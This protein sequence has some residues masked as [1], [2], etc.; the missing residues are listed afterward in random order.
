MLTLE[1]TGSDENQKAVIQIFG[2][3]GSLV[4]KEELTGMAKK[5]ISL[6]NHSNG[7]YLISVMAGDR[8]DMK[9]VVKF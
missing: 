6:E 4:M 7:V 3:M 5:E 9:K 2:M 8:L 1:I